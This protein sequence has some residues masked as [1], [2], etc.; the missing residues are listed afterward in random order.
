[1]HASTFTPEE[2]A[3]VYERYADMLYRVAFS[4]LRMK[5]AAEDA[6][7]DTFYKYID[8]RPA[9]RGREHEKAWFLRVTMNGCRD[10]QRKG[11][12]Q[13]YT[14][15]DGIA[16]KAADEA[17]GSG[18]L[19]DVLRLPQKLKE[20]ILLFY[21][22]EMTVEQIAG[23]LRLSNAAVKMRLARAR[24]ALKINIRGDDIT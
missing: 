6:V 14:P 2:I 24:K 11:R 19:D 20:V 13:S 12:L 1:M 15:L 8:K 22:E 3:E 5:E 17:A 21:F 9:F 7:S 10:I 18:I 4:I 16:D 23:V